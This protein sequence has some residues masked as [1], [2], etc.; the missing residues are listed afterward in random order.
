MPCFLLKVNAYAN[1]VKTL[2]K[3]SENVQKTVNSLTFVE[4][5]TKIADLGFYF[6]FQVVVAVVG[7]K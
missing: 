4:N 5:R 6:E 3:V 2:G 1:I 7:F